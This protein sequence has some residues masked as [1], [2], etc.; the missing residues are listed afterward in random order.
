M[1]CCRALLSLPPTR[2]Q[3]HIPLHALPAPISKSTKAWKLA[4]EAST[5]EMASKRHQ[6]LVRLGICRTSALGQSRHWGRSDRCPLVPIAA[7]RRYP[8][9]GPFSLILLRLCDLH[10]S[11]GFFF[12]EEFLDR[13]PLS[14]IDRGFQ[15]ILK[16][17]DVYG[18]RK[19]RGLHARC[20]GAQNKAGSG[21]NLFK[22]AHVA[23]LLLSNGSK[24]MRPIAN[25]TRNGR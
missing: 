13:S 2:Q 16:S 7:V 9:S 8:V 6:K 15:Q 1:N 19:H 10:R 17:L 4:N 25:G 12:G 21:A 18:V 20:T 5:R 14:L 24:G 3:P 23:P 11:F 22:I